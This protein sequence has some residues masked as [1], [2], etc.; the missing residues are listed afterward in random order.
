MW[1]ELRNKHQGETCV[2]IGNGPSLKET[3]TELLQ[4]VPS[5][6]C[7]TIF[8]REDIQPNYYTITGADQFK[9]ET[10]QPR[11]K[12]AL[13]GAE[14]GFMSETAPDSHPFWEGIFEHPT[15]LPL[16]T[17]D[18][19][20]EELDYP[21]RI[22]FSF[23]PARRVGM[24]ATVTY[25]QLQLAYYMGFSRVICVGLDHDYS[26]RKHFHQEEGLVS[27]T[28]VPYLGNETWRTLADYVYKLALNVYN[29]DRREIINLTPGTKCL[30]FK[31]GNSG[32]W[33]SLVGLS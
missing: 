7:N 32:A 1:D 10:W 2:L 24:H 8:L 16:S 4:V 12:Q 23:D 5:F 33:K 11:I 22:A 19:G 21:E 14:V 31:R 3:P 18:D 17:R 26:K 13:L 30:A 9:S 15:I 27:D 6:G 25:V 20:G 28:M 29:Q